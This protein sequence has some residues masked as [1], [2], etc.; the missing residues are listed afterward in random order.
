MTTSLT[1]AVK[2]ALSGTL[3][4]TPALG[5]AA[6]NLNYGQ[7]FNFAAGAGANQANLLWENTITITASSSTSLDLTSLTDALGDAIVF[8]KV[9]AMAV[10][11]H[12][13]NT[14]NVLV[15]NGTDPWYAWADA[16]TDVITVVPGGLFMLVAPTA[17]GFAVT[18]STAMTLKLANSSSGTSVVL[19]IVLIGA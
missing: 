15:G 6:H 16:G 18:A 4:G 11:A 13:A 1:S 2:I 7:V 9:K 12:A 8:A 10:F 14:N 19:D 17:A 3:A 5:N